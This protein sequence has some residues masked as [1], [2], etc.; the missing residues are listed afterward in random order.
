MKGLSYKLIITLLANV[1]LSSIYAQNE[2]IEADATNSFKYQDEGGNQQVTYNKDIVYKSEK[3]QTIPDPSN[4]FMVEV[5]NVFDPAKVA[6]IQSKNEVPYRKPSVE[7]VLMYDVLQA[8][9]I[10]GK[11][12]RYTANSIASGTIKVGHPS[13]NNQNN[14]VY[15]ISNIPGG[16]GGMDIY[17]S[18]FD[19]NK[20]SDPKNMGLIV[21]TKNDETFPVI[22]GDNFRYISNNNLVYVSGITQYLNLT[23]NEVQKVKN[24]FTNSENK[25]VAT[26][27]TTKT[28]INKS[29][30]S[31]TVPIT[32]IVS[33]KPPVSSI[34]NKDIAGYNIQLGV[35]KTPNWEMLNQFKSLGK[36]VSYQ[37]AQGL[38]N[39]QLGSFSNIDE[40]YD[41]L[42]QV[43]A[44]KWF[45]N[46]YIVGLNSNGETVLSKK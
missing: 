36:L 40:A 43:R 11:W 1:C 31:N 2:I 42:K 8:I 15:F 3:L 37:N 9:W 7:E 39:V 13:M 10:N 26:N 44:V 12:I 41:Y 30:T 16:I 20:W 33:P 32:P 6:Y 46:A 24:T 28:E 27:N 34:S 17:Y 45:E 19:G 14:A 25:P 35:F 18:V 23:A 38:T 5:E 29:T 21:N 4:L 22:D